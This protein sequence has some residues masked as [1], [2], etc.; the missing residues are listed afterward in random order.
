MASRYSQPQSVIKEAFTKFG[1]LVRP[2]DAR[3]FRA[4]TLADVR[5]A[6]QVIERD[7]AQRKCLR[8]LK[9]IEPV[10]PG[11]REAGRVN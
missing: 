11:S 3:L 4:T 8:N 7:Q 2:S 1:S 5:E 9:R 6:A 10:A